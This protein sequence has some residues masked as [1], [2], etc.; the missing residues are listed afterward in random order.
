MQI[1]FSSPYSHL[2]RTLKHRHL[3]AYL[4]GEDLLYAIYG[5]PPMSPFTLVTTSPIFVAKEALIQAGYTLAAEDSFVFAHPNI[6]R[7]IYTKSIHD[8]LERQPF[9]IVAAAA[10]ETGAVLASQQS[11]CDIKQHHLS[12]QGH[13]VDC[14]T[15]EPINKLIALR[16]VAQFEKMVLSDELYAA[17]QQNPSLDQVPK[18]I[19]AREINRLLTADNTATA[20]LLLRDLRLLHE[21]F[22]DLA[23]CIG[24]SQNEY[25]TKD[26][27]EHSVDVV[28]NVPSD[29]LELR[30][31][32]LFHDLC[33]PQCKK[34]INGKV[35]F[36]HHDSASADLCAAILQK[37]GYPQNFIDTVHHLIA[38]H[39]K[40]QAMSDEEL[41]KILHHCGP[42]V[43]E[44]IFVLQAA[45]N[46]A[47]MDTRPY[48]ITANRQRVHTLLKQ[49]HKV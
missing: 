16:L 10:D 48:G 12:C 21:I 41:L 24:V 28:A 9:T 47:T 31:A 39:M 43:T 38:Y 33:K 37:Y 13:T 14:L 6:V 22:P 29:K 32:A 23:S 3:T 27:Y 40:K 11:L 46:A 35:R 2:F 20:L 26:V 5:L 30:M 49:L 17:I 4:A 8:Y 36:P 42:T 15:N 34:Q 45:D 7:L 1:Q 44:D 25:H 18:T 19:I